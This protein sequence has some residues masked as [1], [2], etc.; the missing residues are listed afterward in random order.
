MTSNVMNIQKGI[1]NGEGFLQH[2]S[3][4]CNNSSF[5][6]NEGD[7]V[8]WDDTAH[9]VKSLDNDTHAATLLGVALDPTAVSSNLD[10]PSAPPVPAITVGYGA[11]AS[12]KSTASE[13]YNNGTIVYIGADAQTITTVTGSNPVGVVRLPVLGSPI[14]GATGV[15]VPVLVYS[16]AFVKLSN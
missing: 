16:R 6:V 7:L 4:P 3:V 13:T 8:Y 1:V 14:T 11:V 5:P 2:E 12:L 10:S 15:M 9:L